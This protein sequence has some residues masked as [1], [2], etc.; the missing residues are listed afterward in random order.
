MVLPYHGVWPLTTP[1][2][3]PSAYTPGN[4]N[5]VPYGNHGDSQ[6]P[7]ILPSSQHDQAQPKRKY[8]E[9]DDAEEEEIKLTAGLNSEEYIDPDTIDPDR[10]IVTDNYC[11]ACGV[12]LWYEMQGRERPE[13]L[14]ST[15]EFHAH[16]ASTIHREN[17]S[18]F[19]IFSLKKSDK[20][21]YKWVLLKLTILKGKCEQ[22][23]Q[24]YDTD[25]FDRIIDDIQEKVDENE[26][27]ISLH[28]NNRSWRDGSK[29]IS[30]IEESMDQLLISSGELYS[31]INE[32]LEKKH[33]DDGTSGDVLRQGLQELEQR[34]EKLNPIDDPMQ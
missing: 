9:S 6:L 20:A 13:L 7:L 2:N 29:A 21:W 30:K 15:E 3:S 4:I 1:H 34:T 11:N 23:K 18:S 5:P 33:Q 22:A 25:E 19:Q 26:R 10:V 17:F 8:T 27:I 16:L 24:Q 12:N 14:V 28:E 31:K 32:D